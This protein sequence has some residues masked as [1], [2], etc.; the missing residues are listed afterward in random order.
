MPLASSLVRLASTL[1]LLWCA[2]FLMLTNWLRAT[3]VACLAFGLYPNVSVPYPNV[4][5]PYPNV[6]GSYPNV[7]GLYPG[8]YASV[9]GPS[10]SG[11]W[12]LAFRLWYS[13]TCQPHPGIYHDTY[14]LGT[15]SL[16]L[17]AYWP[18]ALTL[19]TTQTLVPTRSWCLL[20]WCSNP[21]TQTWRPPVWRLPTRLIKPVQE[22]RKLLSEVLTQVFK[23][24]D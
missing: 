1:G 15:L 13:L 7:P 8:A 9:P 3:T 6:P 10:A 24:F 18:D 19:A 2:W 11:F 4:P 14:R 5:G 22:T 17:G 20:A 16:H 21:D 12:C 23:L